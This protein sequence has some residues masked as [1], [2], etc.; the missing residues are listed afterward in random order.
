M[1]S[2][3]PH[4]IW[5]TREGARIKKP[6]WTGDELGYCLRPERYVNHLKKLL[7][8]WP[9]NHVILG[10][11]LYESFSGISEIQKFKDDLNNYLNEIE[12]RHPDAKIIMLSPIA[13]E[14]LEHPHFPNPQ[15]ETRRL[16]YF[17]MQCRTSPKL[18]AS[19]LLTYSNLQRSNIINI[20]NH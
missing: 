14:D 19:T 15:K 4:S 16:K 3:R 7:A 1:D 11:G 20:T 5:L 17:Q 12:R 8:R 13:T 9:A 2:S 6:A 10:F 18:E